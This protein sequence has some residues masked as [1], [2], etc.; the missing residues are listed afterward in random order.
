[1]ALSRIIV[2]TNAIWYHDP[3]KAM[4]AAN[5]IIM[6]DSKAGMFVTLFYGVI[7]EKDRTLT[8][9]NAGHNPPL[10]RRRDG[11]M[12]ELVPT[13]MALG[14]AE[15]QLYEARTVAIGPEDVLL[16]Y[17]DGVTEAVDPRTE[18]FGEERLIEI[19]RHNAALPP[20]VLLDKILFSVQ[21]FSQGAPQFDDITL[22]AI[23]G[24]R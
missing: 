12:E 2:R 6:N 21:E 3:A 4:A 20:G 23:K 14:V 1:M 9:A 11:S 24:E 13:G 22:M 16:L 8:Y 7:S 17:T 19:I 5:D 10:L 18:M 15:H